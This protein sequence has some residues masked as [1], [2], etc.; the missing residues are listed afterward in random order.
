MFRDNDAAVMEEMGVKDFRDIQERGVLVGH[1]NRF[2][3]R[4]FAM[5]VIGLIQKEGIKTWY[6]GEPS[7]QSSQHRT[8]ERRLRDKPHPSQPGELCG[9]KFN[10]D[11][12]G[13]PGSTGISKR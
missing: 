2:L 8:P 12:T 3:G 5:E 9:F 4:D 7:H 6:A 13:R 11:G 1:D 10:P